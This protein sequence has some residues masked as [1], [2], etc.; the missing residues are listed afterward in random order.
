[1]AR[2]P[3]LVLLLFLFSLSPTLASP[4]SPSSSSSSPSDPSLLDDDSQFDP[5]LAL[6][7]SLTPSDNPLLQQPQH[8]FAVNT[9]PSES[10]SES[11]KENQSI[12]CNKAASNPNRVVL[13]TNV[14]PSHYTL[15]ITPDF[16]E[17]TFG[18]YVEIE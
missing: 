5:A 13:P 11:A 9:S 8:V 2:L 14:T 17:F 6:N 18:G 15:T 16:N 12:M 3:C 10:E 1:M 7:F 4:S